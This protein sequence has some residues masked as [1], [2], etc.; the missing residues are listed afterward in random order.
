MAFAACSK[1]SPEQQAVRAAVSYY[2]RLAAGAPA[3][4][5]AGKAGAD[6]LPADYRQQLLEA[7]RRYSADMEHKHGGLRAVAASSNASRRDTS[8]GVVYA[9]LLLS[10]GDSTQEEIT[11][12]MVEY[13]GRWMMK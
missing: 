9:F 12:P 3:D 13:D 10:F 11:V 6:T 4:F 2:E 7:C 8:L 5:F 1:D